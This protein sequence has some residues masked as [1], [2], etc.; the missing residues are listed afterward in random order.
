MSFRDKQVS[1]QLINWARSHS[2][3]WLAPCKLVQLTNYIDGIRPVIIISPHNFLINITLSF[4]ALS[5]R[6][7]VEYPLFVTLSFRSFV[8]YPSFVA[9]SFTFIQTIPKIFPM[10]FSA[11]R[12]QYPLFVAITF[13][14]IQTIYSSAVITSLHGK[15]VCVLYYFD[16]PPHGGYEQTLLSGD[17]LS[18]AVAT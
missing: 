15:L 5:F 6:S 8:V 12:R 1:L 18:P 17:P 9:I 11:L 4:V 16:I 14:F 13:T 7:F 10:I 2:L 3:P